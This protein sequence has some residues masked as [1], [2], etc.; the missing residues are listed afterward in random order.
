M[1]EQARKLPG[2]GRTEAQGWQEDPRMGMCL[3]SYSISMAGA[4]L[5]RRPLERLR[6]GG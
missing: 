3:E 5:G 6:P 2:E 4:Q 1:R